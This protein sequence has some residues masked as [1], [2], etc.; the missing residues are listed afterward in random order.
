MLFAPSR[1][2]ESFVF[3]TG[4]RA[5]PIASATL[6]VQNACELVQNGYWAER[7]SRVGAAARLNISA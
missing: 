4:K 3:I 6:F 5:R 2:Q 7:I 1:A